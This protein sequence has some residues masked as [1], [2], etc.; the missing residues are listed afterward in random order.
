MYI[1]PMRISPFLIVFSS[2]AFVAC[3]PEPEPTRVPDQVTDESDTPAMVKP[4]PVPTVADLPE[5]ERGWKTYVNERYGFEI[6]FPP[7]VTDI[8]TDSSRYVTFDVLASNTNSEPY[9]DCMDGGSCEYSVFSVRVFPA[10]ESTEPAS[11][12]RV[13]YGGNEFRLSQAYKLPH[14]ENARSAF[15]D[16]GDYTYRL[17]YARGPNVPLSDAVLTDFL[18]SFRVID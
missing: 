11:T 5:N 10:G 18:E 15:V 14:N 4:Q 16:R 7:F 6:S 1:R 17:Y 8:E 2:L 12:Q 9:H 3:M 13:T